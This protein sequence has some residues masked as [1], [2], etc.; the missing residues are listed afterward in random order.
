M[1]LKDF[2]EEEGIK[3]YK[4]AEK[5]KISTSNLHY[6]INRTRSP[7]LE[8]ALRIEEATKGEVKC[9]DL[10]KVS[11]KDRYKMVQTDPLFNPPKRYK[12]KNS[13]KKEKVENASKV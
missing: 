1:D 10:I 8:L 9:K 6:I 7:T 13:A 2:L 12:D 4:F 3:F 5:V 11:Q